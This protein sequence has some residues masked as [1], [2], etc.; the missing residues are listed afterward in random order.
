MAKIQQNQID[1]NLDNYL[2]RLGL[3]QTER[4]F[5][6]LSL[7]SGPLSIGELAKTMGL[8][9]PYLYKIIASL[10]EKGLAPQTIKKYQRT[11]VVEPPSIIL[12]LLRKKRAELETLTSS[13]ATDLPKYLASYKQG[14]N[15]TQVMIY[16]G[17][18]K[19]FD[20][21][22]RILEEEYSETLYFG[23]AEHF[24]SLVKGEKLNNWIKRRIEKKIKIKSLMVESP[25]ALSIPTDNNQLRESRYL[26]ASFAENLPAS[27]QVF[28]HNVIFWQ[29][30]RPLAV[31]LR[32]NYIAQMH[33]G[34]FSMLWNQAKNIE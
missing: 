32:D 33:R 8:Q 4:E 9:R 28:G 10:K 23:E 13:L 7:A 14:G 24:L 17:K 34:I 15:A 21:Y 22:D 3:S 18:N 5:Y 2:N 27:F 26:P 12:E 20:I 1:K 6:L 31:V 30:E 29:T 25:L 11:F 16:E 19:Y